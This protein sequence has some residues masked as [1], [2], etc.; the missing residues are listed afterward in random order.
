MPYILVKTLTNFTVTQMIMRR[1]RHREA[2]TGKKIVKRGHKYCE[3]K[4]LA[5]RNPLPAILCSAL[6]G[7]YTS[8]TIIVRQTYNTS[9]R[10]AHIAHTQ[11]LSS[12]YPLIFPSQEVALIAKFVISR[13]I[14][15]KRRAR[16][17]SVTT[18]SRLYQK[19][20]VDH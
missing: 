3:K 14:R 6:L 17:V 11:N 7:V 5:G 18:S 9:D 20:S 2:I 19:Y 16:A 15:E 4:L 10:G 1:T 13:S 8:Q 12:I